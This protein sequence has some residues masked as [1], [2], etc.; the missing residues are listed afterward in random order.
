MSFA[1]SARASR[2]VSRPMP[3]LPPITTTVC[4]ASADSRR[5]GEGVL[6]VLMNSSNFSFGCRY[7]RRF[8]RR[9]ECRRILSDKLLHTQ[10]PLPC[11]FAHVVR[12]PVEA[13]RTVQIGH[14]REVVHD[15]NR[16]APLEQLG[17]PRLIPTVL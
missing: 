11:Q 3:A 4:P 14:R 7:P 1:P 9:G 6:A 13:P 17:P 10:R 15:V 2:A 5:M 8:C 16:Q 12:H